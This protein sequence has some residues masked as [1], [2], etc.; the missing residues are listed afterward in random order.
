MGVFGDIFSLY[1]DYGLHCVPVGDNKNPIEPGFADWADN[2]IDD[3]T[4]N[5]IEA[6]YHYCDRIGLLMGKASGLICFDFDYEYDE[7]KSTISKSKFDDDRVVVE[8]EILKLLPPTP[9]I[10]VGRKGWTRFYKWSYQWDEHSNYQ[11]NR[12]GVRLF[13]L[14][15][16][17]KQTVIPPS[18]YGFDKK[19]NSIINYKWIGKPIHECLDDIP[20][21]DRTIVNTIQY[22]F[23]QKIKGEERHDKLFNYIL[24]QLRLGIDPNELAKKLVIYDKKINNKTYLDDPK[25]NKHMSA[26]AY[27]AKWIARCTQYVKENGENI[28]SPVI[29]DKKLINNRDYFF[30][31]FPVLLGEHKIDLL[32]NK[33]LKSHEIKS[34]NGKISKKWTPV[35]NDIG[36]LRSDCHASGF[37]KTYTEDHLC[38][39]AK[40]IEPSLLIDIK[41]WDGI[42]RLDKICR[43]V[44]ARN[45][46]PLGITE[47]L[48]EQKHLIYVDIV[49]DISA[50]IFRR[51]YDSQEQNLTTILRGGQGVGKNTLIQKVWSDPFGY[52]SAEINVSPDQQKNYDAVDGRI[53][54]VIGEFDQA[55][56]V[57][58]SFIKELITNA[59]ATYRKAY[60]RESD[61]YEFHH[62]IFTASN[63]P[64]VFKDHTGNRR[65][66]IFDMD[67]INME[68]Q[69]HC[70]SDQ[71]LAQFYHLYKNNYRMSDEAKAWIKHY[72]ATETPDD[73]SEIALDIYRNLMAVRFKGTSSRYLGNAEVAQV[74][75]ETARLSGVKDQWIR[76]EI[77]RRGL[78]K[79]DDTGMKYLNVGMI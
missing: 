32:S 79:R 44:P 57:A 53:V 63:F 58:V 41:E 28:S 20:E 13:D 60:A 12:S 75:T 70:D 1:R 15:S 36:S 78:S 11:P 42:D 73:P 27:A 7:K 19:T 37:N 30:E 4:A 8:T 24:L 51:V 46:I 35:F 66:V 69:D 18:L 74:I 23:G 26:E 62:T 72:N 65:Y 38:A 16:W 29:S 6:Q 10:K 50:G 22:N 64:N 56:K 43:I 39:Y 68:Y 45:I 55:S 2:G 9:A 49:K 71:L 52:Y 54:C 48:Y 21:L 34:P 76:Q 33:F 31:L 14:I 61:K 3:A 25:Y 17:H 77:R 47:E 40:T 59:S 5:R 67:Y